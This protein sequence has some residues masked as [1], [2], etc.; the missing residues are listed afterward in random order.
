MLKIG[1]FGTPY[2]EDKKNARGKW[3]ARVNRRTQTG[4]KKFSASGITKAE[5]RAA[6]AEKMA[7]AER[8]GADFTMD[9]VAESYVADAFRRGRLSSSTIGQHRDRWRDHGSPRF[10][11]LHPA[12]ITRAEIHIFLSSFTKIS[13]AP[14]LKT[15]NVV[16]KHAR[17]MGLIDLLPT[18]GSFELDRV[19]KNPQ[20]LSPETLERIAEAFAANS[21]RLQQ[22]DSTPRLLEEVYEVL[23]VTGIR[24]GEALAL[25]QCDYDPTFAQLTIA[26]TMSAETSHGGT[27]YRRKDSGKTAAARRILVVPEGKGRE[28]L[29]KVHSAAAVSDGPLFPSR[30]GT[31]ISGA[32]YRRRWRAAIDRFAPELKGTHPHLVRHTVATHIVRRAVAQ[33]GYYEGLERSRQQ[34]GHGDTKSLLHYLDR[35]DL[36][37]DNSELLATIDP[38]HTADDRM[39]VA[40]Q[41]E[42]AKGSALAQFFGVVSGRPAYVVYDGDL[43]TARAEID[44]RFAG[45]VH[46]LTPQDPTVGA[47]QNDDGSVTFFSHAWED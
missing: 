14:I 42:A 6:L 15:L 1:E 39:L 30:N 25:R 44:K 17:I 8:S 19:E 22:L 33:F 5:A 46:I 45:S 3:T 36:V 35:T 21:V 43:V 27:T 13:P 2:V 11:K 47:M 4:Y 37:V 40:V 18:V 16:F 23:L 12:E 28:I 24:I 10:G 41:N 20:A 7:K 9:K 26:G 31:F 38:R 34:L 32:N 29:A